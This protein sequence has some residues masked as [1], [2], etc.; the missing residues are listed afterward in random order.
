MM[1]GSANYPRG[2]PSML[3]NQAARVQTTVTALQ[4]EVKDL[5]QELAAIRAQLDVMRR[6]HI[7]SSSD[8]GRLY[9]EVA[10]V[11]GETAKVAA[12][13]RFSVFSPGGCSQIE[14]PACLT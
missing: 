3:E 4:Q 13:V 8:I 9:A 12:H 1:Q 14:C 11:R 7:G 6:A 2:N 10:S 5:R